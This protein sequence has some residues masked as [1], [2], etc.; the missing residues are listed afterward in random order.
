MKKLLYVLTGLVAL[1]TLGNLLVTGIPV[2]VQ[3]RQHSAF[4]N[5]YCT[6][7]CNRN[8]W[9]SQKCEDCNVSCEWRE[10]GRDDDF[11]NT[12][13][14]RGNIGILPDCTQRCGHSSQPQPQVTALT[15]QYFPRYRHT[16]CDRRYYACLNN[17]EE[18]FYDKPNA[19]A[20]CQR[21]CEWQYDNCRNR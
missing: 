6:A 9:Y 17:C 13:R 11:C 3:A 14:R 18:N 2:P 21:K 7:T 12:C 15:V 20:A 8:G 5:S 16:E 1:T 19:Y 4:C 10:R